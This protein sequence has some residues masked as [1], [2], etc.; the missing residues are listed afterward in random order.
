[1]LAVFAVG[2]DQPFA[3]L[4]AVPWE[5]LGAGDVV[6]VHWRET[7][8]HEK[9][10]ISSSGTADRPLMVI[11]VPGPHGELPVIDGDGAT[12]RAQ[13]E[14]SHADTQTRGLLTVA[15]DATDFYGFKPS[16]IQIVGLE[17][18]NA[19]PD[20]SFTDAQGN[21]RQYAYIAAAIFVERGE[22]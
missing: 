6:R 17:F 11:G 16:H 13:T 20:H 19:H 15:R 14:Y 18:R 8:Y 12:T 1:M 7:A 3:S 5:T 9:I 2:P 4:G 22:H 10:L 21:E